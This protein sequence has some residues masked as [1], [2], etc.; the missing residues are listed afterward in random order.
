MRFNTNDIETQMVT[1]TQTRLYNRKQRRLKINHGRL[2]QL[3][4]SQQKTCSPCQAKIL[5]DS[6]DGCGLRV[7]SDHKIYKGQRLLIL[8]ENMEPIKAEVMWS[9]KLNESEFRVGVKYLGSKTLKMK[10]F[11]QKTNPDNC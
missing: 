4:F 9:R 11:F 5:D 10:L 3:I 2:V 8:M 1:Q 6:F 7:K